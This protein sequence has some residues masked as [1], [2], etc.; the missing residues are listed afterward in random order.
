M[1]KIVFGKHFTF[2]VLQMASEK[3]SRG[4]MMS[5]D[6]ADQVKKEMQANSVEMIPLYHERT[7]WL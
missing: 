1:I 7:T 5:V 6:A 3:L 4:N 2:L